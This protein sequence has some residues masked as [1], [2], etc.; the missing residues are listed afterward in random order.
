MSNKDGKVRPELATVNSDEPT[1]YSYSF[2]IDKCSGSCNNI[3]EPYAKNSIPEV[4]KNTNLKVFN[5]MSRTNEKRYIKLHET[6][7]CKCRLDASVYKKKQ[8]SNEIN[9]GVNIK[10]QLRKAVVIKDLFG[11][12]IIVNVNVINH[13]MLQNI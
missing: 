12:L 3:N 7:K 6:C 11:I 9:A 1:F 10:N 8:H 2:K 5:I 4:F 13:V